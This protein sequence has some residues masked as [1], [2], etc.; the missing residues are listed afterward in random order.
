MGG[1]GWQAL[2][3]KAVVAAVKR[4]RELAG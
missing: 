4:S 2:M 1:D 3:T